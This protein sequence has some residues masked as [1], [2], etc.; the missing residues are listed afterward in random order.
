MSTPLTTVDGFPRND[1]DV[2]QS[3]SLYS[4]VLMNHTKSFLS[5][6]YARA[7]HPSA[8]RSQRGYGACRATHLRALQ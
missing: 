3:K 4:G 6:N 2:A 1:V 5:T 7:N 8:E